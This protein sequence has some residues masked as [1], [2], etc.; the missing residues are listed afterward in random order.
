MLL[1]QSHAMLDP[2]LI[3]VYTSSHPGGI[4]SLAHLR[5]SHQ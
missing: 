5:A 1:T 3:K 4:S 2:E